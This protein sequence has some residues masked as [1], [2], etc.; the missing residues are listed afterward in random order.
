MKRVK[1]D[2][3]QLEG[4][5]TVKLCQ[6]NAWG[7]KKKSFFFFQPKFIFYSKYVYPFL[8]HFLKFKV[9]ERSLTPKNSLRETSQIILVITKIQNS[10]WLKNIGRYY[11]IVWNFGDLTPSQVC[12]YKYLKHGGTHLEDIWYDF[13][14]LMHLEDSLKKKRW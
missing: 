10:H 14:L 8:N 4:I 12:Y 3:F 1:E 6:F 13:F 5:W 11:R 9:L 7:D 2:N